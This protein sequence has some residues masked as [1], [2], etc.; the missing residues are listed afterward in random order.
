MTPLNEPLALRVNVSSAR[1][2]GAPK[3]GSAPATAAFPG[4]TRILELM[5]RGAPLFDTH[6]ALCQ[7]LGEL[8]PNCACGVYLV[9][10]TGPKLRV[11]ASL[12]VTPALNEH[13]CGPVLISRSG[14]CARAVHSNREVSAGFETVP[15]KEPGG[16][17]LSPAREREG[18][19]WVSPVSPGGGQVSGVVAI[20]NSHPIELTPAEHVLLDRAVRLA[21][22]SIERAQRDSALRRSE[23]F[24]AEAQRLSSTGSFSWN[25]ATSELIWSEELY[26]IFGVARDVPVTLGL[27]RSRVHPED[28]PSLERL[29]GQACEGI[30]VIEHEHRL[31]MPD[32]SLRH[33]RLMA[34]GTFD[35][36]GHLE[37]IG[38]IQDVTT[39][40]LAEEA[41]ERSRTELWHMARVVTLGAL[42]ASIAHEVNQPLSGIITNA[43][44]GLRMLGEE[45]PDVRGA[46]ETLR[47]TLRDGT[48]A[49][50]VI[51]RLRG[52]FG[53]R[54]TRDE[55]VDLNE[56]AREVLALCQ[57]ELQKNGV[58]L[59]VD[60][61]DTLPPIPGDRVQLQQVI[62]NLLLN[63]SEAMSGV[64]GRPR[65]LTVA[66]ALDEA[67]RVCLK[68]SDTGVGLAPQD[69]SRL[70]QPFYTTKSGGMGIGLFVS[71]SIVESH[72]GCLCYTPN[73]DHGA[74]FSFAI[75]QAPPRHVRAELTRCL[76]GVRLRAAAVASP[77]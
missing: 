32:R 4:E 49:A 76:P 15:L 19:C 44:A 8:F 65:Q 41:L 56:A 70:S 61:P 6:S 52:L 40:R 69:I 63:A 30:E 68:V 53:K 35:E 47:R 25:V 59:R 75:P 10:P 28:W 42:S 23:A 77:I 55:A 7:A 34:R 2:P 60:L 11:S 36:H 16:F 1:T 39:R 13:V 64:E 33:L 45:P 24:L 29:L 17:T 43:T 58:Q 67:Q 48:R 57:G 71:R 26:R 9:D 46:R 31:L 22:I 50:S 72:S 74:T 54:E 14:P 5:A 27:L 21:A 18:W 66:T 51:A 20:F 38:A 3:P 37:Y 62:L 73:E 12:G